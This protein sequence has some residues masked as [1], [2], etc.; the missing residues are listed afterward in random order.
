MRKSSFY[1]KK[2]MC[3]K[4]QITQGEKKRK[5]LVFW[6]SD[7]EFGMNNFSVKTSYAS[8]KFSVEALMEKK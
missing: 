3:V 8:Q 6:D 1:K 5:I 2:N 4:I 7:V